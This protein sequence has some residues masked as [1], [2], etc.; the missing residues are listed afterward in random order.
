MTST[1]IPATSIHLQ[2]HGNK[3]NKYCWLLLL[4]LLSF[5][6]VYLRDATTYRNP[7]I[8]TEDGVWLGMIQEHGFTYA[9]SHARGDY[10][11]VLNL[12]FLHF[13][14]FINWLLYGGSLLA[15]PSVLAIVIALWYAFVSCIPAFLFWRLLSPGA[16]I[17]FVSSI[18]LLPL[19]N[20]GYEILA[21]SSNIGF[22][23]FYVALWL[24]LYRALEGSK[25][26]TMQLTLDLLFILLL[27]T[28]PL[29]LFLCPILFW[30]FW[31]DLRD[32]K[33][34]RDY[35]K[36]DPL[37]LL[38]I[39]AILFIVIIYLYRYQAAPLIGTTLSQRSPISLAQI[40]T[41]GIG[42]SFLYPF[43]SLFYPFLNNSITVIVFLGI[44]IGVYRA[45]Q[46][47]GEVKTLVINLLLYWLLIT[48]LTGFLRP[49]LLEMFGS[50]GATNPDRYAM[51]QNLLIISAVLFA[52]L[53][54]LSKTSTIGLGAVLGLSLIGLYLAQAFIHSWAEHARAPYETYA[55]SQKQLMLSATENALAS[56]E[57]T[58]S[59]FVSV[60]I[61]FTGWAMRARWGDLEK[62][63][64]C[65]E[66]SKLV[67]SEPTS[68]YHV[69]P[70]GYFWDVIGNDPMLYWKFDTPVP[71]S[72]LPVLK[73]DFS[74]AQE[75]DA[76]STIGIYWL[77]RNG[78][79]SGQ[80]AFGFKARPGWQVVPLGDL[81]NY[82]GEIGGVRLDMES[83]GTCNSFRFDKLEFYQWRSGQ[84]I[85]PHLRMPWTSEAAQL[86]LEKVFRR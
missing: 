71:A 52:L 9:L 12:I 14:G 62:L 17:I 15:Y 32:G 68:V 76:W 72:Q 65:C 46:A 31:K 55:G 53:H 63:S 20:T 16:W 64:K 75:A 85:M 26:C 54:Y 27:L 60:P 10:F 5:C 73:F 51:T 37:I 67:N 41:Y 82:L 44:L 40:I 77:D 28:N 48:F 13:A 78:H 56:G 29:V 7:I 84:S 34:W 50:Y 21:R 80:R 23:T 8:Y 42:R 57:K 83:L 24:S 47:S 74:C 18:A 36:K 22:S 19:G 1:E 66:S 33:E 35:F 43:L 39:L 25:K 6:V 70:A 45:V 49:G 11:V 3:R 69:K 58:D 86:S 79:A 30:P 61:Y 81:P 4:F 38:L 2:A 59:E